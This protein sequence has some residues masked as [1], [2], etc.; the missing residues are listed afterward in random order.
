M[1]GAQFTSFNFLN[2]LSCPVVSSSFGRS[3]VSVLRPHAGN[4]PNVIRPALPTHCRSK[5]ATT[6]PIH[7]I[8]PSSA[9]GVHD[10]IAHIRVD[11][12]K[13]SLGAVV[14]ENLSGGTSIARNY[15][16]QSQP[17]GYVLAVPAHWFCAKARPAAPMSPRCSR[18]AEVHVCCWLWSRT[19]PRLSPSVR[20]ANVL[21]GLYPQDCG[22]KRLLDRAG[23]PAAMAWTIDVNQGE[24][25]CQC[26]IGSRSI[27]R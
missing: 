5:R 19:R 8:V 27:R 16:A 23:D 12:V 7:I 13:T 26:K 1:I 20:L 9:G 4:G 24:K 25:T 18:R 14:V 10:V 6:S 11:R 22:E 3:S 17:D 21:S 15:V 2:R